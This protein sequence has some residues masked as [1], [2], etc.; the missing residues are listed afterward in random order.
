[1]SKPNKKRKPLSPSKKERRRKAA[2]DFKKDL[3][4]VLMSHSGSLHSEIGP[5]VNALRHDSKG[6]VVYIKWP[7]S[8]EDVEQASSLQEESRAVYFK[9]KDRNE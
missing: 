5:V 3:E 2:Q 4:E 9:R 8:D 6:L 1:M 7:F